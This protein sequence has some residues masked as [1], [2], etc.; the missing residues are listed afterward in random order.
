MDQDFGTMQLPD[1]P[2]A[3]AAD[4][5]DVRVLL[6]LGRGSDEMTREPTEPI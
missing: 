2:D 4:G 1:A 6:R 3:V 5:S